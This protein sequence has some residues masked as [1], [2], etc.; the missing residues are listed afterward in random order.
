MEYR[1]LLRDDLQLVWD[2]TEVHD[3]DV[4]SHTYVEACLLVGAMACAREGTPSKGRKTLE[5]GRER[6][7]AMN[8]WWDFY[9]RAIRVRDAIGLQIMQRIETEHRA[10]KPARAKRK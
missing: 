4:L 5:L 8:L 6:L 2:W 3:E 9:T 10:K 1:P 7:N